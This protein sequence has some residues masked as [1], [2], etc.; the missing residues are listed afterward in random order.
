M[1]KLLVVC[2]G[3]GVTAD[4]ANDLDGGAIMTQGRGNGDI[5]GQQ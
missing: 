2:C 3:A 5:V 4:V 1:A